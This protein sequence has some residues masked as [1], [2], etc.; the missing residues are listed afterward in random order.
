MTTKLEMLA[1]EPD[2]LEMKDKMF[3]DVARALK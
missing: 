2:A 3:K 1:M